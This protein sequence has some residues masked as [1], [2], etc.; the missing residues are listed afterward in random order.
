[1]TLMK[2]FVFLSAG[3]LSTGVLFLMATLGSACA[4]AT[5]AID[6]SDANANDASELDAGL[7]DTGLGDA[8]QGKPDASTP[9]TSVPDAHVPD[10]SVPDAHA[11]DVGTPD[12]VQCGATKCALGQVCCP[13]SLNGQITLSCAASCPSGNGLECDGPEDCAGKTCCAKTTTSSG[14]FPN[15]PVSSAAS[16]CEASCA[17]SIAFSC[18]S[19]NTVRLCHA[20]SDCTEPANSACCTFELGGNTSTFCASSLVAGFAKSCAK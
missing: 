6:D 13:S 20:K 3:A 18:A 8:Q 1:M 2:R 7:G 11:P 14:T 4:G 9:D 10:T 19:T 12:G 5:V 15:C 17:T 16:K